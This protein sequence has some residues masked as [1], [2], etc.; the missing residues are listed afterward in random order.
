MRGPAITDETAPADLGVLRGRARALAALG[1]KATRISDTVLEVR[2]T[3]TVALST[4]LRAAGLFTE[5]GQT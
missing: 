1:K 3:N 4:R 5:R 2:E